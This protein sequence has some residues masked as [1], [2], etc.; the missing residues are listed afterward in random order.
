ML[1]LVN[2]ISTRDII[3]QSKSEWPMRPEGY[4]IYAG[5]SAGNT[6]GTRVHLQVMESIQWD[7]VKGTSNNRVVL[8]PL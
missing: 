8:K 4:S 7:S 2:I 1:N 3:E 6:Q 5:M